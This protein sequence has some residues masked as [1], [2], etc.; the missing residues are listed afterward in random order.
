MFKSYVTHLSGHD[1]SDFQNAETSH[2]EST[3]R[4]KQTIVNTPTMS[5]S[6]TS[7]K[8][9]GSANN[10]QDPLQQILVK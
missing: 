7:L 10:M 9:E 3:T 1:S 6:Q 2:F 4:D 5:Q 8:Q